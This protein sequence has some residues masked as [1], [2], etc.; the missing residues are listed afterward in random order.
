MNWS[1]PWRRDWS[2][3]WTI[4]LDTMSTMNLR[5]IL[6]GAIG[7]VFVGGSV[8]VSGVLA[9]APLYTVQ[10]VRYAVACVL[11]CL[12]ARL[13][14]VRPVAPRGAEWWW[15][16]GVTGTGL[17]VFNIALVHGARHA[18]PAVL[19]V[20]VACVP[21]LLA[22]LGPVLEGRPPSRSVLL[23]AI[24][25][26][27][28]SALV[29]GLGRADAAGLAWAAV[30]LAGETGFTLLAVPLLRR[31][32]PFGISVHTTWLAAVIFAVLGVVRE[33]PTAVT[34]LDASDVLAGGYLAVAVT[35][36]AFVLWYSSV[37]RLGAGRAGLLTGIAPVA[38]AATGVALG[39]PLPGPAVWAG[40][41]TVAA[42]LALGLG[43]SGT[44]SASPNYA[45]EVSPREIRHRG[46]CS[47]VSR[48]VCGSR[49]LDRARHRPGDR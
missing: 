8:A 49:P 33:G 10:A 24:V 16:L 18:E 29:Q 34:R 11:L 32:G 1:A 6:S 19:G 12:V 21:V 4:S 41:A 35:A 9:D 39:G 43:S 42:G 40:I 31:H 30:V 25:V 15:L 22:L 13:R 17:V 20:A 38:A 23:A 47:D 46:Q 2:F 26:T 28:G 45:E 7:M 36:V 14:G 27:G 3:K 5:A 44:G 37:E 48:S